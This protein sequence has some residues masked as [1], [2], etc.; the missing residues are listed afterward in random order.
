[1]PLE[2]FWPWGSQVRKG[3]RRAAWVLLVL[4][5]IAIGI[6]IGLL[7]LPLEE[8]DPGLAPTPSGLS[9]TSATSSVLTFR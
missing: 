3:T 8:Q 9:G 1:M 4:I 2:I 6:V 7:I 5:G